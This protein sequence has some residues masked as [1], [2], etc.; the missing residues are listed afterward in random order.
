[1]FPL[2]TSRGLPEMGAAL[3][4]SPTSSS[5]S[6]ANTEDGRLMLEACTD[7]TGSYLYSLV[8]TASFRCCR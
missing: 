3:F 8:T 7:K 5:N 4:R 2:N 1:Q 6:E